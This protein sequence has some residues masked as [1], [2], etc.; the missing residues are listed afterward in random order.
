MRFCRF[1]V[2]FLFLAAGFMNGCC[3]LALFSSNTQIDS[4]IDGATALKWAQP[5]ELPG[6]PNFYKV[7]DDLYRG[8][9]PSSQGMKQ[10]QKMGIKTIVSL[11]AFSSDRD[12]LEGVE[13]T[14][15]HVKVNAWNPESI[16]VVRFLKIVTDS[17]NTPVFVH[18]LQ[19]SDRTGTMCAIYRIVVQGWT[20]EQAIE[21]MTKGGFG[22]HG[23]WWNLPDYIRKLDIEKIKRQA[24]LRDDIIRPTD[25]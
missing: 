13:L 18:C 9:Q 15:E 22:Y 4:S 6:V 24:G 2:F 11:R 12:E 3:P 16:D 20:K 1:V 21:E 5:L 14:Y 19:G 10:L 7:S 25:F 8:A 23:F 17:N